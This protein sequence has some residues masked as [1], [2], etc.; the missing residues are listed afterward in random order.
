MSSK[1]ARRVGIGSV[2]LAA[3]LSSVVGVGVA[4]GQKRGALMLAVA[5]DMRAPKDV[6]IVS[7]HVQTG[8]TVRHNF[9]GRVTPEGE[10]V[11]PATLAIIEPDDPNQTI[12]VRVIALKDNKPLVLRDVR[13]T[14]PHGGRVALLRLPL[15]FVNQGVSVSGTV[16]D[17]YLPPKPSGSTPTS[18]ALG[19]VA[20]LD[21]E[22]NPYDATQG[23]IPGCGTDFTYIDGD[24]CKDSYVDSDSLPDFSEEAVFGSGGPSGCFDA[25]AC[26]ADAREIAP[27]AAPSGGDAGAGDAGAPPAGP[28][29]LGS[30]SFELGPRDASKLNL[31]L[32]TRDFGEC[33]G[34]KCFLPIDR[35]EGGWSLTGTTVKLPISYCKNFIGAGKAKLFESASCGAKGTSQPLC[36]DKPSAPGA[37]GAE[38]I[39]KANRPSALVVGPNGTLLYGAADGLYSVPALAGAQAV[40]PTRLVTDTFTGPWFGQSAGENAVF[41][42]GTKAYVTA[43]GKAELVTGFGA[44][45]IQGVAIAG[46]F[47]YFATTGS[48]YRGPTTLG[49]PTAK[50]AIAMPSTAVTTFFGTPG[51]F[52]GTATGTLGTCDSLACTAV[53]SAPTGG[54]NGRIDA[55]ALRPTG[56]Q[57]FYVVSDGATPGL[58]A[59]DRIQDPPPSARRIGDGDYSRFADP[60]GG[61]RFPR[62]VAADAKCVYFA[63][64]EGG[65]LYLGDTSQPTP[66]KP[67][68]GSS[69][70]KPILSI[71][72]DLGPA[73]KYVYYTVYAAADA[74]GGVYRAPVPTDCAAGGDGGT[75]GACFPIGQSCSFREQCCFFGGQTTDCDPGRRECCVVVGPATG[76]AQCCSAIPFS[77][78]R[79]EGGG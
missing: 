45:V 58:Y 59:L 17:S 76:P 42:N 16:P 39:A 8:S 64:Q 4:C 30:C 48:I 9:I 49:D 51:I 44:D 1:N 27:S 57:G 37:G 18:V 40:A 63:R 10:V 25:K 11:F 73:P 61:Q 43:T 54:P 29:D 21:T 2:V 55:I 3:A 33:N 75:G 23:V 12:R 32:V 69:S 7:I 15:L 36:Q 38:L 62:P 34:D 53:P 71:A 78:G 5:T 67:L 28:L 35:G 26:F 52:Y 72:P 24:G 22:W 60:A 79:C 66:T 47:S 31:A 77:N 56:V 46:G 65:I 41:G 13:T 74:G 70:D 6:N 20:L 68:A 14:A 19:R 50:P